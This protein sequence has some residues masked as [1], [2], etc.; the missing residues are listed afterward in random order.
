MPHLKGFFYVHRT[1]SRRASHPTLTATPCHSH[2]PLERLNLRP[3][4]WFGNREEESLKS[5]VYQTGKAQTKEKDK[6]DDA[7]T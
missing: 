4:T 2:P 5:L 7:S 3:S 1:V 6:K